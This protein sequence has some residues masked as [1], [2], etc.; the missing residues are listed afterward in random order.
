MAET[1]AKP[2][3]D[4]RNLRW[5]ENNKGST[6]LQKMGWKQG[7]ALGSKRR[8]SLEGDSND[9][10]E[11]CTGEGLK[12]VKRPDG[13]G[14]GMTRDETFQL[15]E[16]QTGSFVDVLKKL[17]QE[18]GP[19]SAASNDSNSNKNS[20]KKKSKKRKLGASSDD[21]ENPN[22][23]GDKKERS[24]ESKKSSAKK[25]KKQ[26]KKKETIFAT[27]K[28][29]NSKVRQSK[30]ATKSAIDM[31]C[32]FGKD[33]T[34]MH[35]NDDEIIDSNTA[36]SNKK[37]RKGVKSEKRTKETKVERQERKTTKRRRQKEEEQ[38]QKD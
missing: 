26:Q 29:T 22:T 13:L 25:L 35:N 33:Y 24:T 21:D 15:G 27:N 5:K 32:I 3:T 14:L 19:N 2:G 11:G 7:M 9:K 8:K 28:M 1:C 30:F 12:I 31:A 17:Q 20:K 23:G 34:P 10:D 18:H 4:T 16:L 38:E 36:L 37:E 6:L